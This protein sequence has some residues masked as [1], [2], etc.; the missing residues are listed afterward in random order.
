MR[1]CHLGGALAGEADLGKGG[2]SV[3][4]ADTRLHALAMLGLR[5]DLAPL[6][7]RLQLCTNASFGQQQVVD[8]K[9]P[10]AVSRPGLVVVVRVVLVRRSQDRI[11]ASCR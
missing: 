1:F 5:R 11:G 9:N 7:R 4:S 3:R 2:A 10:G 6:L 8:M